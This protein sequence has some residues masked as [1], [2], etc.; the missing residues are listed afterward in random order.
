MEEDED[1]GIDPEVLFIP[2]S[3]DSLL[4]TKVHMYVYIKFIL[5]MYIDN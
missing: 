3:S 5:C 2:E 4:Y 1:N